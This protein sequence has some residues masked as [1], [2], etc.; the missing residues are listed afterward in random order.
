MPQVKDSEKKDRAKRLIE[1]SNYL[2][3][4]YAKKFIGSILDIIPEQETLGGMM[5]GHTSNFLQ[6]FMPKDLDKIGKLYNVKI[7]KIENGKIYGEI[8]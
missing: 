5:M 2:E 7:T 8:L 6:V 3:E 1:L 4:E